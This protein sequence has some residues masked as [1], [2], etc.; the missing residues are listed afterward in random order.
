MEVADIVIDT[1]RPNVQSMVQ[2]ILM[3]LASANA[4]PRPTASFM[5]S[6]R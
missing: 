5:Q 2:T 4:R 1:G 6:L 3:Q